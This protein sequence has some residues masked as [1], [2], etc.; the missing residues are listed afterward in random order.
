MVISP[1]TT[2]KKQGKFS[3]KSFVVTGTLASMSREE[4]KSKIKSLGGK[5]SESVSSKTDYLIVGENAG[6]KY[7]KAQK[8]GVFILDEKAFK[9]LL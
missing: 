4:A 6:S 1:S 5:V 3:G 9:D 2:S 7:E 8:L